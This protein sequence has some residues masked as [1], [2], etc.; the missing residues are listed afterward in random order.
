[1]NSIDI[2]SLKSLVFMGRT[3]ISADSDKLGVWIGNVNIHPSSHQ[4]I[5]L[6]FEPV[7]GM[8][9]TKSNAI[10]KEMRIYF[11]LGRTPP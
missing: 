5:R 2:I 11:L 3:K 1:M 7:C 6:H 8:G 10:V 9:F 4:V